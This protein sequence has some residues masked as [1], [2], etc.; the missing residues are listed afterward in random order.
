[1]VRAE[2]NITQPVFYEDLFAAIS[3][4]RAALHPAGAVVAP[5]HAK[6]TQPAR[7]RHP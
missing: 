6:S 3:R 4:N 5:L 2:G 7:S 1:M